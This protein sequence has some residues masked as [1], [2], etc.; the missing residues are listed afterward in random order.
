MKNSKIDF[1]MVLIARKAKDCPWTCAFKTCTGCSGS[2][3]CC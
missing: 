3:C 1:R 2:S